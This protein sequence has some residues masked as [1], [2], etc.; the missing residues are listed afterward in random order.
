MAYIRPTTTPKTSINKFFGLNTNESGNT[1]LKLGESGKMTNF[2]I[3]KDLKLEKVNGYKRLFDT[4]SERIDGMITGILNGTPYFIFAC[5][6]TIYNY[7]TTLNT[8][9]TMTA[10]TTKMFQFNSKVYFIN[11][12]EFKSW[13][14]TIFADVEGYVPTVAIGT[15]P[16]GGG[17]AFEG[18]NA[19]TGKKKQLFSG[20][21]SATVYQ[22]TETAIT[23]IVEV[24]VGGVVTT[25]YTNNLTNG[26][27]TFTTAPA[28]GVNNVE[29]QWNKTDSNR[30]L[31]I[32]NKYF[33]TFGLA[34]DTRVFFYGNTNYKNRIRFSDLADGVPSVEYF[35][36]L[37]FVDIEDSSVSV[38]D[39]QRQYDRLVIFTNNKS[40]YYSY[41]TDTNGIISF[42]MFPINKA[43]G[44][45]VYNQGQV[46]NNNIV[47]L[48]RGSIVE[49]R[50]TNVK[51]ERNANVIS[52]KIQELLN[53]LDL[54]KAITYDNQRSKEYYIAIDNKVIIYQYE[55]ETYSYMELKHNVTC[56]VEKDCT[57][58][59][60]TSTGE[61]M[62]ISG[63]YTNFDGQVIDCYWEGGFYD[64]GA[65]Y[66]RKN[67]SKLWLSLK[68]NTKS[69][70]ILSY[71]SDRES[72]QTREA[73]YN[74]FSFENMNFADFTFNTNYN[75]KP[76]RIRLKAKKF[77]YMKMVLT[78]NKL[79][80]K[81][82]VTELTL[83]TEYVGES[84]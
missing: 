61:I 84:K 27:V 81:V 19:L 9:G 60:G 65:E 29:I 2:R 39:I 50:A 79:E 8:L 3:T 69:S 64:F 71:I 62:E 68:P 42:P 6:G 14:G 44:S 25:A 37:N 38:M 49:W 57:L 28:T 70:I 75:P 11:G 54:S 66:Q 53:D 63:D 82:L 12:V 22:L 1:Q 24:K 20:N 15:P 83:Q 34:N 41:Y 40:T 26:T 59:F 74:I 47:T 23:S 73:I 76:F 36:I 46:L 43:Y 55:N 33:Q 45:I 80:D 10:G 30:A 56:Y 17:T 52:Q 31:I 35:P 77:A 5:G 7:T 78:N 18:I 67:M 21:G 51:D 4:L 58:Y 13:N 72:G 32:N 48:D 16:A